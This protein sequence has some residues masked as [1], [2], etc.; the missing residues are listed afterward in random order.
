M[1][2]CDVQELRGSISYIPDLC[3][4]GGKCPTLLKDTD[5][6]GGGGDEGDDF[7][8]PEN[9]CALNLDARSGEHPPL[10]IQDGEV[11]YPR[12]RDADENRIIYVGRKEKQ[13]Y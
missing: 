3:S 9:S 1:Y 10:L 7:V 2:C 6:A 11:K 12:R 5:G 13:C 8:P 4:D